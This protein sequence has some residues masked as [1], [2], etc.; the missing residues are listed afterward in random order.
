MSQSPD[1]TGTEGERLDATVTVTST[2]SSQETQTIE[3]RVKDFNSG[4]VVHT[5]SQ[6]VTLQDSTDSEQITLSWPTSDGDAGAYDLF[7]ESDQDTIQRL[8]EVVDSEFVD[9]FEDTDL[10]PLNPNWSDWN[11]PDG[12]VSFEENTPISGNASV[13]VSVSGGGFSTLETTGPDTEITGLSYQ[14]QPQ[15]TTGEEND[16]YWCV[17]R[18]PGGI[19]NATPVVFDH[20]GTIRKFGGIGDGTGKRQLGTWQTG[21]VYNVEFSNIDTNSETF[22]V[23]IETAGGTTVV[24]ETGVTSIPG[25][26]STTKI[27]ARNDT[28]GISN[29]PDTTTLFDNIQVKF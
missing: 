18:L 4:T 7:L 2:F 27:A 15:D 17:L 29:P 22:D 25:T 3:L 6:S 1:I 9:D 10:T 16:A 5:D 8:V 21:T 28:D 26:Q 23:R 19:Q 20:T 14:I 24:S 11:T 12:G 13:R